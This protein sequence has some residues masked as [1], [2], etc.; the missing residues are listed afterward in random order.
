MSYELMA[1]GILLPLGITLLVLVPIIRRGLQRSHLARSGVSAK[2][3]VLSLSQT[4]TM[5]NDQPL[6]LIELKVLPEGGTPYTASI[7]QVV[8]LTDIPKVQPGAHVNVMYDPN[9]PS[10]VMVGGAP[11]ASTEDA[12]A[13]IQ[14]SQALLQQLNQP[15]AGVGASAVVVGF[16]PAQVN[17]KRRRY[18]R[19]PPREGLARDRCPVQRDHR[20]CVQPGHAGEVPAR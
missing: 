13:R 7:K 11:G 15:G 8:A 5:I 20:R 18:A 12:S 17:V 14:N 10:K 1:L 4:G 19:H 9:D 2:A 3:I 6:C 16:D